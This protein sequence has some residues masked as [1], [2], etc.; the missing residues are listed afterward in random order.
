MTTPQAPQAPK[1][2]E[3][4][5]SRL[6]LIIAIIALAFLVL[7]VQGCLFSWLD[8]DLFGGHGFRHLVLPFGMFG[9][10]GLI[11]LGL[12]VWV[13]I[14]ANRRGSNGLLWG[15]LVFFA[16]IVGLVVYLL[17]APNLVGGPLRPAA[18][19]EARAAPA[20]DVTCS[21]CARPLAEE[22]KLC[23]YCGT[24]RRCS[25]CDQPLRADWKLCPSCG[26]PT[27]A[28]PAPPGTEDQSRS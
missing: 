12:A 16:P 20:T 14:D 8:L 23:P 9:V 13:G 1:P 5:D 17:I 19:A 2:P 4:S 15:A 21:N 6:I 25:G 27:P 28:A 18:E 24:S 7:P 3:R 26:T 22:F 11:Q 10:W